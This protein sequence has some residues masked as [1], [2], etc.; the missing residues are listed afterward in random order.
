MEST[1]N[2]TKINPFRSYLIRIYQWMKLDQFRY[3]FSKKYRLKRVKEEACYL[4]ETNSDFSFDVFSNYLLS[5]G[6]G[7]Q[8]P[9]DL[10]N[11]HPKGMILTDNSQAQDFNAPISV[12][13][14]LPLIIQPSIKSPTQH[15]LSTGKQLG[16]NLFFVV[17]TGRSGTKSISQ[18]LN[19]FP[20]VNCQHEPNHFLIA[21]STQLAHQEISPEQATA[22][23][24]SIY[25]QSSVFPDSV[26][27]ESDQKLGNLIPLLHQILPLAKFV[28]L[29]RNAQDFVLSAMN[30]NWYST[31]EKIDGDFLTQ[32]WK[33]NRI[34]GNQVGSV[35]NQEWSNMDALEKCAWYWSYWNRLIKSNLR[36]IPAENYIEIKL[37]QFENEK[38]KLFSFLKLNKTSVDFPVSNT[39]PNAR[40]TKQQFWSNENKAKL[41]KWSENEMKELYP[42]SIIFLNE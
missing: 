27:G 37:E 26:Y 41:L 22:V 17:S 10:K 2:N 14:N 4:G 24:D 11:Q 32:L 13:K 8:I 18:Y 12:G 9:K 34:Q 33:E 3:S 28:F 42:E 35:N 40:F 20:N 36:K 1:L 16:E 7:V 31:K 6:S 19:Q 39:T 25:S 23:L 30:K 21:L 15:A 5:I 29:T 38:E